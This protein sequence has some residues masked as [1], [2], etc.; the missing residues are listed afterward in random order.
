MK[1]WDTPK[2]IVLARGRPEEATLVGCKSSPN[3]GLLAAVSP[4]TTNPGCFFPS[5]A[6][7][8]C[9]NC[10]AIAES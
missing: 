6:G 3:F 9:L 7:N 8:S 5:T 2:L 1:K 10:S 4:S